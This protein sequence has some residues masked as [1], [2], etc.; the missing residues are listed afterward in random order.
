MVKLQNPFLFKSFTVGDIAHR[1][2]IIRLAE[3]RRKGCLHNRQAYRLKK[4]ILSRQSDAG[5]LQSYEAPPFLPG[6]LSDN[7]EGLLARR[8]RLFPATKTVGD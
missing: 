7:V 8:A 3:A 6:P 2:D 1:W 5:V 4:D